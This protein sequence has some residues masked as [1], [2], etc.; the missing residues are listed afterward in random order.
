M[1]TWGLKSL[2]FI[3]I[4]EQVILP[5]DSGAGVVNVQYK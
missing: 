5:T 1:V 3:I 4:E 2:S